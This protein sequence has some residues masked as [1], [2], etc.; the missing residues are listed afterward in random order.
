MYNQKKIKVI[1]RECKLSGEVEENTGLELTPWP[2]LLTYRDQEW[3]M[4]LGVW[5]SEQRLC[6][7]AYVTGTLGISCLTPTPFTW[8]ST[9]SSGVSC[10]HRLSEILLMD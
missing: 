7:D 5:A 4:H 3:Q 2:S 10:F 6:R 8:G 1:N 9:L